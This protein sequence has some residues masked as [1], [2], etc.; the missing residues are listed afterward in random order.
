MNNHDVNDR[1][2]EQA[3]SG[4]TNNKPPDEPAPSANPNP[5]VSPKQPERL[6]LSL[7]QLIASVLAAISATVAASFFGVAGTVIGAALGSVVSVVG[8][9]VYK[10]SLDTT[11][12][13]IRVAAIESAVAQRFGVHEPSS[14]PRT[15]A[16]ANGSVDSASVGSTSVRSASVGSPS[17][18]RRLRWATYLSPKRL[19]L[20][21]GVLFVVTL[22]AVTA[23]EAI[24]GQPI[25]STVSNH[26]G[27]G[28]SLFGGTLRQPDRH[29][30]SAPS[31]GSLTPSAVN[32]GSATTPAPASSP[33]G[34]D[35]SSPSPTVSSSPTTS[36]SDTPSLSPSGSPGS[37][38]TTAPPENAQGDTASAVPSG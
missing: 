29:S 14:G 32:S 2:L 17:A 34:S 38:G 33:G 19:A 8:S 22:G 4:G 35:T 37:G 28:T 16:D 7:T 25:S 3:S 5:A 12:E 26:N 9:A 6:T 21:A 20:L 31:T 24:S 1:D 11:R 10:H 18:V 27:K 36:P 13:R 23:F 30:P 15:S